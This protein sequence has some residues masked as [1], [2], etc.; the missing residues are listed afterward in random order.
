M[1]FARPDRVRVFL[2]PGASDMRRAIQGLTLL[3]QEKL[4]QDPLSGNLFVF[5]NRRRDLVKLLYWDRNGFCLWMKRLERDRFP[6]PPSEAEA[7]EITVEQL[8]W[9]LNGIDFRKAHRALKY[10]TVA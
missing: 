6:W 1:I 4:R 7:L 8:V 5:C 2:R 9:L 3:T 10:S